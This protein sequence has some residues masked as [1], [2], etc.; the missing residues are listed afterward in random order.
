MLSRSRKF[1]RRL[2]EERS[3][4]ALTEFALSLPILMAL[5]LLGL[6]VANL[7]MANLRVS[8]IAM[9]TAD[10]AA[11]VRIGIDEADVNEVL[12]GSAMMGSNM[13]FADNGRIVLSSLEENGK[14]GS[15]AG[16]WIRWQRCLG[17]KHSDSSWGEENDGK[18][19]SSLP[20]MGPS[21]RQIS[22]SPGTAV[23]VVEVF[24]DYQPLI[25]D[26]F[27]DRQIHYTQAFTV[28]DRTNQALGNSAGVSRSR[29]NQYNGI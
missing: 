7:A 24:Y 11:R 26:M 28:R 20:Y 3:G 4:V 1:V 6:E 8:Q 21:D 19:N 12:I 13:D 17:A 29:C 22:A 15:R 14:T 27:A 10:S 2:R 5:L 18:N 23:M 9:L 16:Q 25:T